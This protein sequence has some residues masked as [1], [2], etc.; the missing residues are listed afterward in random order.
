MSPLTSQ[1]LTPV[2]YFPVGNRGFKCR[3]QKHGAIAFK[4]PQ[5]LTYQTRCACWCNMAELLKVQLT[6]FSSHA[7]HTLGE[8][9][10][11]QYCKPGQLLEAGEM[12]DS[13]GESDRRCYVKHIQYAY[14]I[15]FGV[16]FTAAVCFLWRETSC[17]Q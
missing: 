14:Q 10:H 9:V 12:I 17:F 2:V 6:A 11:G 1:S 8:G 13:H 15:A 16:M 4:R 5:L 3:K 7:R